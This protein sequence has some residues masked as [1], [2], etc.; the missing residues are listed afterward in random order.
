MFR[1]QFPNWMIF[2]LVAIAIIYIA[3]FSG[4]LIQAAI[5]PCQNTISIQERIIIALSGSMVFASTGI[6]LNKIASRYF[7]LWNVL[8]FQIFLVIFLAWNHF[9]RTSKEFLRRQVE[10]YKKSFTEFS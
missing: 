4:L 7:D 8:L 10:L 3:T 2:S 9:I 6:L 1:D 5:F